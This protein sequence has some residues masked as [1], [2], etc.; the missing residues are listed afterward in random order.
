VRVVVDTNVIVSA[1]LW[2]GVPRRLLDL[3][4]AQRIELFTTRQLIAE[5][6]DVLSREKLAMQLNQ[7]RFT[8]AY[9]LARYTQLARLVEPTPVSIADLR[10]PDDAAVIACAFAARAELIVSGDKD[11]RV[12]K[13][14]Q[15][16]RI[17][18]VAEA[19]ALVTTT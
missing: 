18:S 4:E 12:L 6:K 5:L 7:T 9:L 13:T 19:L 8:A 11:L 16:I 10:D 15:N 3:A 1:F 2:G 14:Y 17:V